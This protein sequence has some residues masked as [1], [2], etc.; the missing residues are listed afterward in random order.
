MDGSTES[1]LL[2]SLVLS[3]RARGDGRRVRRVS[4]WMR[5]ELP[6]SAATRQPPDRPDVEGLRPYALM[7]LTRVPRGQSA[8][9]GNMRFMLDLLSTVLEQDNPA[10]KKARVFQRHERLSRRIV[11]RAPHQFRSATKR[12]RAHRLRS[13]TLSYAALYVAATPRWLGQKGA[14]RDRPLWAPGLHL[15]ATRLE[16]DERV[17]DCACE[18]TPT[19]RTEPLG[20]GGDS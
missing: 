1:R 5:D 6:R 14:D 13:R 19:L 12:V 10:Q 18:Y 4:R 2:L 20:K 15:E 8:L 9:R 7:V 17:G 11:S 16:T 3:G